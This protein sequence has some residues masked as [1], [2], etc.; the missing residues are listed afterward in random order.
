VNTVDALFCLQQRV[1]SAFEA[2]NHC[3]VVFLDLSK[4]F[5]CM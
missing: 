1:A 4:A 3:S 2:G 5:D